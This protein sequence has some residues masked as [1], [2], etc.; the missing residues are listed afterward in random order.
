M[1]ILQLRAWVGGTSVDVQGI[2]GDDCLGSGQVA[3]QD[4]STDQQRTDRPNGSVIFGSVDNTTR[5]KCMIR[6]APSALNSFAQCLLAQS[7]A[8]LLPNPAVACILAC[9]YSTNCKRSFPLVWA[10]RRIGVAAK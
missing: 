6:T 3:L 9:G 1:L 2:R 5:S 4:R 10:Y 7:S 8:Q